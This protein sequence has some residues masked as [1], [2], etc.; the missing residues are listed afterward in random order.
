MNKIY[1]K[2]TD[3]LDFFNGNDPFDIAEKY[4][5]TLAVKKL[6]LVSAPRV[7]RQAIRDSYEKKAISV[8]SFPIQFFWV[9]SKILPHKLIFWI[10]HFFK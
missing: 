2:V 9:A 10:M 4:G 6:T 7:V 8:C 1:T 5:K 3:K